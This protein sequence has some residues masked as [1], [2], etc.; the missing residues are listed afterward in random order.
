MTNITGCMMNALL[1]LFSVS[2]KR[3]ELEPLSE[4]IGRAKASYSNNEVSTLSLSP[5]CKVH[6]PPPNVNFDEND[7]VF[8]SILRGE[9]PSLTLAETETLLAFQDRKPRAPLHALVIPKRHIRNVFHLQ[10]TDQGLLHDM[11]HMGLSLIQHH[12][13]EAAKRNDFILC[14]HVPPF[15]SVPH[16]HLHV[17]APASEMNFL[18]RY[19]KYLVGTR[20]CTGDLHVRQRLGQGKTPVP[21]WNLW[22]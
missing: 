18:H 10:E 13:P 4:S 6:S 20:W 1:T 9:L 11:H 17:L 22:W 16:L 12:Y 5:T 21:Y 15:S 14:Y 2:S 8:G 3:V 7:S 19:G